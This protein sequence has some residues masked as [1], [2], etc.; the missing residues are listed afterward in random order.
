MPGDSGPR[1]VSGAELRAS[2]AEG[3]RLEALDGA[4][5]SVTFAAEGAL[6]WRAVLTRLG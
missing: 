4:R 5:M 3:W 1:R 2:F 6:A